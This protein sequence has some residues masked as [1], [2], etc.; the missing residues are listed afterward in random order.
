[1]MQIQMQG[2]GSGIRSMVPN[3]GINTKVEMKMLDT[4]GLSVR[5]LGEQP[6]KGQASK[7]NVPA[8]NKGANP[9]KINLLA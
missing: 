6:N 4:S 1:M 3:L 5:Q 7:I 8:L 9:L 2:S